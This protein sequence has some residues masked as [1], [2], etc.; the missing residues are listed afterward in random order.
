MLNLGR[1]GTV[2][3]I[4]F[5]LER[6]ASGLEAVAM[7]E[8]LK[9]LR[10]QRAWSIQNDMQYLYVHRILIAYFTEKHKTKNPAFSE[11]EF[12]SKLAKFLEEYSAATGT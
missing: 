12:Q 2:V 8:L 9:T 11:P 3:A 7:N 5:I 10:G 6:L 1:T 4:E